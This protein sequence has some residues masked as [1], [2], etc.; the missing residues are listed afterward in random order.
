MNGIRLSVPDRAIEGEVITIKAMIQ[1]DME[2]GYRRD[3]MGRRIPRNILTHFECVYGGKRVFFAEL[4]VGVAANPFISFYT[5]ATESGELV[6]R[7]TDQHGETWSA[8]KSI[9]VVAG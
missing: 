8:S 7:W 1:H 5:R 3:Q 4:N 9:E 6:F 2:S